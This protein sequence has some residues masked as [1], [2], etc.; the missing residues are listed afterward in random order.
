[1]EIRDSDS[2]TKIEQEDIQKAFQSY[3]Q[4]VYTSQNPTDEDIQICVSNIEGRVTRGMNET[5]VQQFARLEVEEALHQMAPLKFLGP[6]GFG[7][8]F[9]QKHWS[10]VGDNVSS[11]VFN[12]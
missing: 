7:A 11:A 12:C 6:D 8:C 10:S 3:F 9:Y 1:M 5:L 4:Q 2:I